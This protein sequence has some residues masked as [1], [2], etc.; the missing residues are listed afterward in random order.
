MTFLSSKSIVELS[1][2]KDIIEP[3]TVD[4]VKNGAYELSLG[5]E[6]FQTSDEPRTVRKLSGHEQ[7]CIE[8]GHFALLLTAETVK[9]PTDKIAFISIKATIKFQ[10]LVNVSGFHVDPGFEGQLLFSVY[11]AGSYRIVLSRG[12]KYFPIWFAELDD[13]QEYAG[14]HKKQNRIPDETIAALSQ[15]EINA[16][17]VL[18]SKI[19][20]VRLDA[21][22]RI[23]LLERDQKAIQYLS[24]TALGFVIAL[25]L[26]LGMDWYIF[27]GKVDKRVELK[28]Q[29][30]ALDS[31][32]NAH[33]KEKNRLILEM[34]SIEQ[35]HNSKRTS[36][37]FQK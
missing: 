30:V 8:P 19:D 25:I 6:V 35:I 29:E 24:G 7:I 4:A 11:N 22:K 31:A 33:L 10:G 1:K 18:N 13:E 14:V 26:K 5:D 27:D 23:G 32:I 37:Q 36:T 12:S 28:R 20:D 34:D 15:G 9:I 21:D 16:P 2:K 3:F 17:I